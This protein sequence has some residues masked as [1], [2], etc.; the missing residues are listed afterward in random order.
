M[1]PAFFQVF[2]VDNLRQVVASRRGCHDNLLQKNKLTMA[3]AS[4]TTNHCQLGRTRPAILPMQFRD[5]AIRRIALG[6]GMTLIALAAGCGSDSA[7]NSP[8]AQRMSG[9][10]NAYLD[11]IVG[12]N[13]PPANETAFKKHLRGLRASVQY[14]YKIDPNNI[15]ASFVSDRDKEP[16]V[17]M[18]GTGPGK[19]SG[20]S[21]KVIAYEKTGK[22]GKRLVVFASTKVDLVDEAELERLKSAKDN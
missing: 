1:Y 11:H 3:A 9:L 18:Y 22:N 16:L 21:K 12:A 2:I 4:D 14:D 13:G 20:D 17:V 5:S 19:I 10:A 7:L 6:L 8:T 15:D